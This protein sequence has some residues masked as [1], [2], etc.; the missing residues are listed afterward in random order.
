M[1]LALRYGPRNLGTLFIFILIHFIYRQIAWVERSS[2]NAILIFAIL[3]IYAFTPIEI[4]GSLQ[5]FG[6]DMQM[7]M[8]KYK[9]QVENTT[10]DPTIT[11]CFFICMV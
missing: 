9:P 4:M 6:C 3:D 10:N 7:E 11:P 5:Q 8:A 1:K 2:T